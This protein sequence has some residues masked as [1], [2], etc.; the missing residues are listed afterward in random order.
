LN[1]GFGK[2]LP[3]RKWCV[4]RVQFYLN[5]R[6]GFPAS[7]ISLPGDD[8]WNPFVLTQS[9]DILPGR[10]PKTYKIGSE[11]VRTYPKVSTCF[12][13]FFLREKNLHSWFWDSKSFGFFGCGLER[14]LGSSYIY[15]NNRFSHLIFTTWLLISFI[16]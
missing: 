5:L 8:M 4:G 14:V 3:I 2:I 11:A 15:N 13:W 1:C 6:L 16:N 10:V 7:M 9:E 12:G